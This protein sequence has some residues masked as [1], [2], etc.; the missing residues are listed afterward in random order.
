MNGEQNAS[1]AGAGSHDR[2]RIKAR[3]LAAGVAAAALLVTSIV[4]VLRRG[5][6]PLSLIVDAGLTPTE[7]TIEGLADGDAPRTVGRVAAADGTVADAVLD[8]LVVSAPSPAALAPLLARWGGRIVD[9]SEDDS[10]GEPHDYLVRI[11][12]AKAD[13]ND[14]VADLSRLEPQSGKLRVS[15]DRLR[16]LLAVAAR[17]GAVHGA[18]V[19][20]NWLDEGD[21][22]AESTS[23]EWDPPGDD[24]ADA[25]RW[26]F[27]RSSAPQNSGVTAAWRLLQAKG[28]LNR[29]VKIMV[30]D[31]GFNT[32]PDFPDVREIHE[33]AWNDTNRNKCSGG[34]SCPYHGTDVV[35]TAM[36][37]LDNEYGTAGPAGPVAELIAVAKY[38]DI[39]KS[40]RRAKKWVK[41]KRPAI[42]NMSHSYKPPIFVRASENAADRQFKAMTE[43]GAL[44][45]AAAGNDGL[46]VD[47]VVS[48][49]AGSC[50]ESR[51]TLPCESPYVLCVGGMGKDTAFKAPGSA[52]GSK[53]GP[54]S[55]EIYGPYVT[56]GLED[57]GEAVKLDTKYISGT[58]F[59]SPFV[60][61]V[62]ALV[63]AANPNL[64]PNAIRQILLDTAHVGGVAFENVIP[65]GGRR[66]N[67]LG[68]VA[69]ALGVPVVPPQV[70]IQ[71]PDDGK[72]YGITHSFQF[73]GKA[74][75]FA[76]L[77]IPISWS[78]S[79]DGRLNQKPVLG[80][81]SWDTL[82]PG[83]HVITARAADITGAIGTDSVTVNVIDTPPDVSIVS[84]AVGAKLYET[85]DIKLIG[86]TRDPDT[87]EPVS[88]STVSWDL[89]KNGSSVFNVAGHV[90]TVPAGTLSPGS[91]EVRFNVNDV[92]APA[93]RTMVVLDVPPGET[94]PNATIGRPGDGE[95][96]YQENNQK[97]TITFNGVGTDQQDGIVPGT[98]FRWTAVSDKGTK[99]VLCS[100]SSVPGSG[101]GGGGFTIQKSC[102]SFDLKLGL[103]PKSVGF[104]VYAITLEVFD[105]AGLAGTDTVSITIRHTTG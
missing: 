94:V 101:G 85:Q 28:K 93:T 21:G 65:E 61:G 19:S 3:R 5:V 32:N 77:E 69:R 49:A 43:A 98:R 17:E 37:K 59:A 4:I 63:K 67:A 36:G 9:A 46:D 92:P 55:V 104:T 27:L 29:K 6:E 81:L 24:P 11:D 45:V 105:T 66:I 12:P 79:I 70:A 88:D 71:S 18:E 51:Q 25:Y 1:P 60:A 16:R 53:P 23:I 84:P 89:R 42:V 99:T 76:G 22:I 75:D 44:L 68:A 72:D 40:W 34:N 82:T 74:L 62:A 10:P 13:T 26:F 15:S 87:A 39:W 103:D 7:A 57:A 80:P 52:F 8:E 78:S 31:G 58:S 102:K 50:S 47:N 83:T 35:M 41:E 56:V 90:A 95:V 96:F 2:G 14:V 33:A 73:R 20:L 86:F 91:Y 48:C 97:P 30:V 64:G 100:G 38:K 54:R